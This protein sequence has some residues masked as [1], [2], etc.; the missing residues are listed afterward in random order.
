MGRH[1][2]FQSCSSVYACSQ[3]ASTLT[4]CIG[5][6]A[7]LDYDIDWP[8]LPNELLESVSLSLSD[9]WPQEQSN[10]VLHRSLSA[11]QEVVGLLIGNRMPRGRK[12]MQK[13]V[14]LINKTVYALSDTHIQR[15]V[16]FSSHRS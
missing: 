2:E 4:L 14:S 7:R 15:L 8:N 12:L 13:V 10:L 11:I 9:Q 16:P 5:K 3:I 6:I 1:S